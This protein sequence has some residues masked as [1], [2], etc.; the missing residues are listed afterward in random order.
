MWSKR[1]PKA[2]LGRSGFEMEVV[3]D[4]MGCCSWFGSNGRSRPG[5]AMRWAGMLGPF[6]RKG[7]AVERPPTCCGGGWAWGDENLFGRREEFS[8]ELE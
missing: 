8:H 3:R 6:K 1:P 5:T 2:S 4:M 7:R